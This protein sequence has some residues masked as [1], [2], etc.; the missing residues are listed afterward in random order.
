MKKC[1]IIAC[2]HGLGH[3]RRCMLMA[4]QRIDPDLDVTVFAPVISVSRLQGVIPSLLNINIS[5]FDTNTSSLSCK[6]SLSDAISWLDKLPCLDHYDIVI[7]DNLPEIL[8]LRPDA[9]ISAQFFWHIAVA[10]CSPEYYQYCEDLLYYHNPIIIGCRFFAMDSV[11]SRPNFQP[12]NMYQI[13]ELILAASQVDKRA[14]SDLLITGGSTPTISLTLKSYI[15]QLLLHPPSL[16]TKVHVDSQLMPPA[17]P[18]WMIK[19]DFTLDMYLQLSHAICRPGLGT[20]TDLLTVNSLIMPIY[21]ADNYEMK[22]NH[23]TLK[24]Y[25]P[26]SCFNISDIIEF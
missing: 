19:A 12:A 16:F 9:I 5:N 18:S 21:E 7:C 6:G 4:K 23:A 10:N 15:D 14:C 13:P 1:A 2:G 8:S 17:P 26:K 20:I 3:I 22:H 11:R 24:K 25:F